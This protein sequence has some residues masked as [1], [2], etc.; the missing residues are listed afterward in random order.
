[1]RNT[2][3]ATAAREQLMQELFT[4]GRQLST[5][6]IMFHGTVAAHQGISATEEKVLDLL[7]RNGPLTN[8]QLVEH[9]GL[10]PA[11][12][13]GLVDR[14]VHKGYVRRL[15]NPADGRSK[16]VEA[17]ADR[18]GELAPYFADLVTDLRRIAEGY[19][20][21]QLGTVIDFLTES[22][23]AQAELTTRITALPQH[24]TTRGRT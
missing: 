19:T 24:P 2:S 16:L 7:D 1:V 15:P 8:S 23:V 9:S 10:A 21:E 14:L 11:S 12:V 22:A 4:A 13:T 18:L 20:D 3:T 5:A 17:V 6:T